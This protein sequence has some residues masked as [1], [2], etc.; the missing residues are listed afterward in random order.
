MKPTNKNKAAAHQQQQ[1]QPNGWITFNVGGSLFSTSRLTLI[2]N[3]PPNSPLHRVSN[4][5]TN[6]EWDRDS[7]GA[8]MIDR[9][10]MFFQALLNYLRTGHLILSRDTPAEGVLVE[11][12]YFNVPELIKEIK[13]RLAATNRNH[14]RRHFPQAL[15]NCTAHYYPQTKIY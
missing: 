3:T 10:P 13:Q 12:E 7:C 1:S 11:A 2:K 14:R 15:A 9:D 5:S 4:G 6:I 8:Y